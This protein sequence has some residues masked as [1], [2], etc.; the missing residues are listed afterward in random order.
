[1]PH[2]TPNITPQQIAIITALGMA[3]HAKITQAIKRRATASMQVHGTD[4]AAI[5]SDV[6]NFMESL[7]AL[8]IIEDHIVGPVNSR[9]TIE[10]AFKPHTSLHFVL[11]SIVI[12]EP[13]NYELMSSD[14]ARSLGY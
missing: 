7:I 5:H 14:L 13:D 3:N 12:H 8:G 2:G 1:M 6:T 4:I 9:Y 11:V 10:V